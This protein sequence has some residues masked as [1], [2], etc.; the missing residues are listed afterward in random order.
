MNTIDIIIL[1]LIVTFG[2]LS[3]RKGL[4]L[5][6]LNIVGTIAGFILARLYYT[7]VVQYLVENVPWFTDL[8]GNI[9]NNLS[10]SIEIDTGNLASLD[11]SEYF[12]SLELPANLKMEFNSVFDKIQDLATFDSVGEVIAQIIMNLIGFVLVFIAVILAFQVLGLL[13]R[14]ITELPVIHGVN[15][16][17]GFIFGVLKGS[18]YVMIFMTIITF[19]SAFGIDVGIMEMIESSKV[20]I[21][22]YHYNVIIILIN[23][24]I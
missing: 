10:N 15:K 24:F 18:L 12:S 4:V 9:A 22:F 19:L 1:V 21:Y 11:S 2:F 13:L 8:E 7:D 16:L 6:I 17:G 3:L 20:A 23:V 14:P 5:S